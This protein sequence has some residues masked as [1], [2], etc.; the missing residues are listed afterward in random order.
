MPT[1]TLIGASGLQRGG[2]RHLLAEEGFTVIA[3]AASAQALPGASADVIVFD[4]TGVPQVGEDVRALRAFHPGSRVVLLAGTISAPLL[5]E[6]LEAGADGCLTADTSSR[7]LAEWLHFTLAGGKAFPRDL[8]GILAQGLAPSDTKPVAG[9]PLSARERDILHGLLGGHSNKR[10]ANDL[11]ITEATVKVHLKTL[12]R[13]INVAN[14]T[15]AAI[16]AMN[17]GIAVPA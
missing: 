6:A 3:E 17:N 2:L 12:L 7:A 8:A 15:Q 1:V 5:R 13:K 10:I 16:W 9:R 11:G 4:A 14:R